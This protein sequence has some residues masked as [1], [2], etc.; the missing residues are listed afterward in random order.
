ME[1]ARAAQVPE[2][3]CRCRD[4][5]PVQD[6][7]LRSAPRLAA[8]ASAAS[9]AG[10]C[11]LATC[12]S[13]L[14]LSSTHSAVDGTLTCCALALDTLNAIN[15]YKRGVLVILII[16]LLA[17]WHRHRLAHPSLPSG[18]RKLDGLEVPFV[19]PSG[20]RVSIGEQRPRS[21]AFRVV[22]DSISGA[23]DVQQ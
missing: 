8:A 3:E 20:T 19:S 7:C 22:L 11:P 1:L 15:V 12:I 9:A 13:T 2:I 21:L 17:G 16:E 18:L 5:N 14:W 4:S 6:P 10:N 23:T